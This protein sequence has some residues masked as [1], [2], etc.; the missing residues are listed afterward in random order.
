MI[1]LVSWVSYKDTDTNLAPLISYNLN[2]R[3]I[4]CSYASLF[5]LC[6]KYFPVLVLPLT[7]VPR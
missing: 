2:P 3:A 1:P 6:P 5:H 7:T 4:R